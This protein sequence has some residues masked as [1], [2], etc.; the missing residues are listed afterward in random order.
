[1]KKAFIITLFIPLVSF[2]QQWT[3][4]GPGISGESPEDLSG[5]FVSLNNDGNSIVI[6]SPYNDGGGTNAGHVRVFEW[7]GSSWIQKG[8]DLD[9]ESAGDNFGISVDING[10]GNS[11]IVGAYAND[12]NGTD[13]GSARVFEWNG[14]AWMQKGLDIDG[15]F[16]GDYSG[17]SVSISSDGDIMAI[18]AYFNDNVAAFAGSTRI[19]EWNGTAWIQKGTNL[20]GEAFG[21][22]SGFSVSLNAAGTRVAIGAWAN[23]DGGSDAG[24]CRIYDWNGSSWVQLGIDLDGLNAG[25]RL[26]FS[27]YLSTDGNRLIVGEPGF[28]D[29]G[30]D[31]GQ[32][33]AYSWSG[34]SWNQ[35]GQSVLGLYP[36]DA[37]GHA[38]AID[39]AGNRIIVGADKSD[40]VGIN[41]GEVRVYEYI[42]GNWTQYGQIFTGTALGN[43]LGTSVDISE[44]GNTIAMGEPNNDDAGSNTGIVHI[45]R[46]CGVFSADTSIIWSGSTLTSNAVGYNYQWVDCA[47]GNSAIPGELAQSFTPSIDGTYGVI[48]SDGLCSIQSSCLAISEGL[49][50]AEI[51]SPFISVYPNPATDFV[52]VKMKSGIQRISVIVKN[53]FGQEISHHHL[54][55]TA[56]F[57]VQLPNAKGVYFLEFRTDNFGTEIIRVINN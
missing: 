4:M 46:E 31:D 53:V 57:Q 16:A 32:I 44:D 48:I 45:Y 3:E 13:S 28:N 6:G 34:S 38:V 10:N 8:G 12:G 9:G 42:G 14:S 49:G 2:S 47:N 22:N 7:N 33:K 52:N 29:D 41:A 36:G 26:G 21:D 56:S 25:D 43:W 24:Q 30:L 54:E 35:L 5:V 39:G 55:N 19:Y 40:T 23:N 27:A 20:D 15:E 50:V 37:F 51:E 1:M 17:I 11:I 18:G